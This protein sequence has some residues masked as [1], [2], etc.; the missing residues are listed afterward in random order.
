MAYLTPKSLMI[1]IPKTGGSWCFCAMK[2]AG[3]NITEPFL[4]NAK[5]VVESR[6]CGIHSVLKLV[7]DKLTFSFIRHPFTWVRSQWCYSCDREAYKTWKSTDKFWVAR[8]WSADFKTFI[9]N[10][11][12]QY[13]TAPTIGMLGRIGFHK[14]PAK[15]WQPDE[16]TV[17]FIGR[18]ENL[19]EDLCKALT[20]AGEE[21]DQKVI[22]EMPAVR[23]SKTQP[24]HSIPKKLYRLIE[25]ANAPLMHIWES[26]M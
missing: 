3:I 2:A 25:Q 23:A 24:N 1:H 14:R 8:C 21:F 13:S 26:R 9:H 5:T 15:G 18:T 7:Q 4:K 20:M 10:V 6:H 12:E 17:K 16:H 19:R 11:L 22:Y